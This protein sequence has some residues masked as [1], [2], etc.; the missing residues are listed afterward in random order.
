MQK[1]ITETYK[2]YEYK[3][4]SK[5]L[6]ELPKYTQ[7]DIQIDKDILYLSINYNNISLFDLN[8]L[9][10]NPVIIKIDFRDYL[11]TENDILYINRTNIHNGTIL[12]NYNNNN[13]ITVYNND[14]FYA[15]DICMNDNKVYLFGTNIII[16]LHENGE[17]EL[18]I[19][20]NNN[21][22]LNTY[23]LTPC[24]NIN[25][26]LYTA[27]YNN[28]YLISEMSEPKIDKHITTDNKYGYYI[29]T[30]YYDNILL[31]Y[32]NNT[33]IKVYSPDLEEISTID[34]KCTHHSNIVCY[35]KSLYYINCVG[36]LCKEEYI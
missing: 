21:T 1:S 9:D 27:I 17:Q 14:K 2:N 12:Y 6:C 8:N 3:Y 30:E 34:T 24:F 33:Q 18:K 36:D 15:Y 32:R 5:I 25:N 23:T 7:C 22:I 28:I 16:I 26:S 20:Y 31:S 13:P 10:N 19:E 11:I 4:T 29:T 35:D